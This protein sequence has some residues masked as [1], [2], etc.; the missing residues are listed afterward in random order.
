MPLTPVNTPLL[1]FCSSV[2]S[3]SDFSA[4]ARTYS[5]TAARCAADARPSSSGCSGATTI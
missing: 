4:A 1:T 5:R 3:R 2:R